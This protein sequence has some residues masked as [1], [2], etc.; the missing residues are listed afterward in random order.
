M[1]TR[2][3]SDNLFPDDMP[4]RNTAFFEAEDD[5]ALWTLLSVYADGEATPEE[6]AKVEALLRS[7]PVAARE[8]SFLQMSAETIQTLGEVE[9]P[10]FLQD[11]ILAATTRRKSVA[12]RMLAWATDLTRSVT[13]VP[14]IRIAFAGSAV[15]AGLLAVLFLTRQNGQLDPPG[16]SAGD[17]PVIARTTPPTKP[18]MS[19]LDPRIVEKNP[20]PKSRGNRLPPNEPDLNPDI[21]QSNPSSWHN[22]PKLAV[23]PAPPTPGQNKKTNPSIVQSH[24]DTKLPVHNDSNRGSGNPTLNLASNDNAE[25]R[26]MYTGDSKTDSEGGLGPAV[27]ISEEGNGMP[28]DPPPTPKV[29]EVGPNADLPEKPKVTYAALK[30]PVQPPLY[31]RANAEIRKEAEAQRGGYNA[32][33]LESIKRREVTVSLISGKF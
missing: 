32:E 12:Q 21:H 22:A 24:N 25:P 28:K 31:V 6:A 10:A 9:P 5:E 19:K 23:N 29:A 33:T 26:H 11:S 27:L 17:T 20:T 2:F 4:D 30:I 14:S 15:L 18:N 13:A 8:L 16:S 3:D 1:P 7:D